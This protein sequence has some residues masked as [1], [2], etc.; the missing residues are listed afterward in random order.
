MKKTPISLHFD[1]MC[2]PRLNTNFS[3]LSWK[4]RYQINLTKEELFR[5]ASVM[6]AYDALISK[7]QKERNYVA[8]K[9]KDDAVEGDQK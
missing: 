1:G 9:I 7:S 4:L 2:W 6:D 3:E 5:V 8:Q